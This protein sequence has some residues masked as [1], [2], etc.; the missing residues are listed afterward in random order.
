MGA[1]GQLPEASADGQ[2]LRWTGRV[3]AAAD[4]RHLNGHREL[5]VPARVVITPLAWE[6]LRARGVRVRS[7]ATEQALRGRSTWG[8]AQDRAYPQVASAVQALRRG[9]WVLKEMPSR[10]QGALCSW[11]RVLAEC[12]GRGE[13]QGGVVFCV[14]P[15]LACC[16]ANKV[17]GLRAVAVATIAQAAQALLTLDPNFVAVEMPGRTF[18][19]IQHMI[20]CLCGSAART[21]PEGVA[22]TLQELDGHAHR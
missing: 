3:V 21:C 9:G 16:V 14:D 1:N 4:L 6:E 11:S 22:C 18:F 20:R 15:G 2:V 13:C 8:F 7:Q 5:E 19:E 10:G 17:A 12:V